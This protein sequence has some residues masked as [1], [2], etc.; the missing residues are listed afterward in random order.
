M[1]A[2]ENIIDKLDAIRAN[3]VTDKQFIDTWGISLE[4]HMERMMVFV[5]KTD[6]RI[7]TERGPKKQ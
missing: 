2:M 6:A 3:S 7:M 4:E 5:Q 1:S